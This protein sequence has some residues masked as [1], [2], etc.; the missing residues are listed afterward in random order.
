MTRIL[1]THAGSLPRPAELTRLLALRSRGEAVDAAELARVGEAATREVIARQL[2]VGIDVVNDGEVQRESFFTYVQHRMTGFGGKSRRKTMGDLL[3][4]PDYL[5]QLR[6]LRGDRERV[7]LLAA[8]QAVAEVTYVDPSVIA[9][10]C[11]TFARQLSPHAGRYRDAFV[12]APSPGIVAAAMQNACYDSLDAYVAALGRA[13]SVEYRAI[14]E[15]GFVLQIDAPDLALERHTL[16]QD[17]PLADF[18]AFA[19]MVVDQINAALVG[20]PRERVRLHVCWGNYEGA[21]DLD[22]DLAEIAPVLRRAQVGGVLLS[23]ANP[24][25]EHEYRLLPSLGLPPDTCVIPGVID[26]TTNYV[27]HPQV[28]ADRIERVVHALGDPAR[29]I[30][31]TDCGFESSAGTTMVVP[32]IAW[33]KLRALVEGARIASARLS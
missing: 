15:H 7:D 6:R 1:T 13:L 19:G 20:L 5:E 25:H 12:T 26:T 21:H 28:V 33:A 3:R 32:D 23:M 10:D 27:E 11:A 29:V 22:V 9:G 4:Y 18:V 14:V 2:D 17:A 30:A 8:P 16:F 24:R 31:G